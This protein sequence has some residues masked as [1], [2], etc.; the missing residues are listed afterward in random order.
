[1]HANHKHKSAQQQA[2]GGLVEWLV[3]SSELN[4]IRP[5]QGLFVMPLLPIQ[6]GLRALVAGDTSDATMRC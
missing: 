6:L 1:M 5:S 3:V 4:L 2:F